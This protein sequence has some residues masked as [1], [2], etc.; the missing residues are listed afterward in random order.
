MFL[1]FFQKF[2]KDLSK[3]VQKRMVAEHVTGKQVVLKVG[4][5]T[6]VLSELFAK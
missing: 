5:E 2:I 4:H 1:P 3:E 6:C